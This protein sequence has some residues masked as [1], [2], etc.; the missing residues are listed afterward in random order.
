MNAH[1]GVHRLIGVSQL[2]IGMTVVADI[3]L[4]YG[5]S[6]FLLQLQRYPHIWLNILAWAILIVAAVIAQI[7]LWHLGDRLPQWS[8][9]AWLATLTAVGA[10]DMWAVWGVGGYGVYPTAAL[11][12]GAGLLIAATVCG[13]REIIYPAL[14][15][16]IALGVTLLAESR[17]NV[18]SIAPD[19]AVVAIAVCPPVLG[20]LIVWK[21]RML[22]QRE[23]DLAQAQSTTSIGPLTV[24]MLA[25]DELVRLDLAAERLLQ[26]VATG[27]HPL[28]LSPHHA[29]VAAALA[30]QLRLHLI[31]GRR[32]TW[33]YHAITESAFLG[34]A[35]KLNDPHGLAG[36]LDAAQR[37]GLLSAI[38]LLINDTPTQ[39]QAVRVDVG[40][41]LNQTD[42]RSLTNFTVNITTTGV[43][44]RK[45]DR[46]TWQAVG[47]VGL[48]S[49][50]ARGT[51]F[52]VAIEC[53]VSDPAAH[54]VH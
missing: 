42:L 36:L 53:T 13:A 6:L 46:S 33:L 30:T 43:P 23:L 28:P 20:V 27:K 2:G 8:I 48:Y 41:D 4:V 31:E 17:N 7:A 11:T 10:L 16:G 51:N 25:S 47:K 38:W 15:L 35:V 32:E 19:I 26:M 52:A 9:T 3:L 5:L 45:V 21:F 1:K 49:E 39:D 37:D 44:R 50:P 22:I 18:L 40:T 34:P 29:S 54:K 24:G 14:V 12:C